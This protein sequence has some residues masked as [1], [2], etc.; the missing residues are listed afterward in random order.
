MLRMMI[1]KNVFNNDKFH[2]LFIYVYTM[3]NNVTAK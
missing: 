2:L 1:V 3:L